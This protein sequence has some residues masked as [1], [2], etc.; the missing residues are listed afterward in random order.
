M[1]PPKDPSSAL[2][3]KLNTLAEE[4]LKL[5]ADFEPSPPGSWGTEPELITKAKALIAQAQSPTDYLSNLC[6]TTAET[7]SVQTL[8]ELNVI[9]SIPATGSISAR[10]VAEKT[11]VQ[12]SLVIRLLRLPTNS[13]FVH[14]DEQGNYSHT[15]LSAGFQ[16]PFA[17]IMLGQVY[18]DG[19]QP[20]I[21]LPQFLKEQ[22]NETGKIEE[23]GASRDNTYW[24]LFTWQ[25]GEQGKSSTFEIM[26]RDPI[27]MQAFQKNLERSAHLHPYVGYYDFAKLATD[28]PERPVFVDVGGGHGYAVMNVLK[29][30]PQIRPE[31]CVL[32]DSAP[33]IK[34]AEEQNKDLPI[35]VKFQP[36]DFFQPNPIKGARA[37]YLRAIAHDLSDQNTIRV[38][39]QIVPMMEKDSK[40]LIADNIIPEGNTSGMTAVMDMMMMAIGGKERTERNF[41]DVVEEAGLKVDGVYRAHGQTTYAIV[42]AS[43][44]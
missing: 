17:A 14:Q 30:H 35:G 2:R 34:Y 5:T 11:G 1:S 43:L 3:A 6:C 32:Q 8:L 28:D 29:H 39:K 42:E 21:R 12:E 33:V 16:Q 13:G 10:D 9:Q 19:L 25:I 4:I 26:E 22:K 40:I 23:P 15:H 7:A 18:A 41:R 20:L 24:N 38:L 44:K 31:Q 27:K 37:Y 36:H